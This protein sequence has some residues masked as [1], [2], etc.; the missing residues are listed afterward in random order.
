M[1]KLPKKIL[2]KRL[3]MKKHEIEAENNSEVISV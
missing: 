1:N 2:Q 3:L